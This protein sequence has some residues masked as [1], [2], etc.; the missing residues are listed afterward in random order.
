MLQLAVGDSRLLVMITPPRMILTSLERMKYNRR[1]S[2]LAPLLAC[3][4]AAFSGCDQ[5]PPS[6]PPRTVQATPVNTVLVE[7]QQVRRTSLQPATIAAYYQAEIHARATGYI[8][9]VKADIGDYVAKDAPLAIIAIPEIDS[10][11]AVLLAKINRLQAMEKQTQAGVALADARVKSVEARLVEARSMMDQAAASLAAAE[12][13]LSRTQDLVQRQSLQNRMLDEARMKRD[14]E[15]ARKK[16]MDSSI[17][18]AAAEVLVAKA[19][20]EAAEADLVTA[21]AETSIAQKEL[22]QLDVLI[23]FAIV[24]APFA[25]FITQR[26][27]EPG[28]LVGNDANDSTSLFVISQID[29]VRVQFHVPESDAPLVNQ[30][31]AVTLTLPSFSSQVPIQTTVTRVGHSLDPSTRLMLVECELLNPE[32]KLLPG[33]FGQATVE[34]SSEVAANMLPARAVRFSE[35]GD[36]YVYTIG[37]DDAVSVI[38][39][40]TGLD[41]GSSIEIVSGLTKGQRVVDAH[42]K[43]FQDGQKVTILNR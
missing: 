39:V 16:A 25:G 35:S 24:K 29:T 1:P 20:K 38:P 17:D 7:E 8:S 21:Q 6:S 23:D 30:G 32:N 34:L 33:M 2:S 31:D 4:V 19:Q 37:D 3:L 41:D 28:A 40:T 14:S 11:R 26:N 5:R 27:A 43:R 22:E 15:T 18:S 42:L 10:Q 36:A 13:E 12:A 9:E